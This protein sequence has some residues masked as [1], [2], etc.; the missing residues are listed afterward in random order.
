MKPLFQRTAAGLLIAFVTGCASTNN[1]MQ[2]SKGAAMDAYRTG[3]DSK[4]AQPWICA[5]AGA[6]VAGG[7][8]ST[9]NKESALIGAAVGGGLGWWACRSMEK[10]LPDA[11]K[12]G[13][14]DKV[15]MCPDTPSGSQV[16]PNGCDVNIDTDGD[17]IA[18]RND[19]C[20]ATP[21]GSEVDAS[22]CVVNNDADGDGVP[23]SADMC[24]NTPAG[25][26]VLANGCEEDTDGD[27][28]PDAAD[29]CAGT[30][31]EVKVGP[32]GCALD[33]DA[34]GVPDALDRC[35]NTKP[36]VKVDTT[37]CEMLSPKSESPPIAPI[38]DKM[39][40]KGVN[41]ES[42]S[43]KIT[44]DSFPTL[45]NVALQLK[46]SPGTKV[47]VAGF[48]D[49]SGSDVLNRALS[50]RR[51]EMVMSYL[52]AKGVPA[53][54]LVAKGYGP[55]QPIADNASDDGRAQNRRVELR[56]IGN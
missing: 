38:K 39:V 13:V 44:R 15:D 36:A 19:K 18:D 42:G 43:A 40:L 10:S 5:V 52:I 54:S 16:T 22:G 29:R 41:F 47:E 26:K 14:P 31:R 1:S 45:D 7:L 53:A 23:D 30:P 12:D 51:A 35:P 55:D 24:R 32:D 27:G 17:G 56:L 34:D 21:K 4:I 9:E 6:L 3:Q 48:T 11:D 33:T 46:A 25:A 20:A 8:A 2:E 49:N 50:Q 37:G 28:V